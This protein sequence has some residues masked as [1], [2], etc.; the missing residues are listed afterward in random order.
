MGFQEYRCEVS[1]TISSKSFVAKSKY[2][3]KEYSHF[4]IQYALLMVGRAYSM[5][6][7]LKYI[8]N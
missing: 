8:T 7:A 2:G 3:A 1:G 6:I 5:Y 4:L